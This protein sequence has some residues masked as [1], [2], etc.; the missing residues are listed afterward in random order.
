MESLY[1]THDVCNEDSLYHDIQCHHRVKTT[2][3]EGCGSNCTKGGEQTPF[4]CVVCVTEKVRMEISLAGLSLNTDDALKDHESRAE[5]IAHR[6]MQ[7]LALQHHRL[8][9]AVP[10]LEPALQFFSEIPGALD[11]GGFL[12]EPGQHEQKFKRPGR[13]PYHATAPG[14]TSTHGAEL[15]TRQG[16]A[17]SGGSHLSKAGQATSRYSTGEGLGNQQD[18]LAAMAVCRVLERLSVA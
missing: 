10:K 9:M 6:E 13:G 11:D 16:V 2:L 14:R 12:R 15:S 17:N 3:Y 7:Q 5:E 8:T 18:D 1:R 4:I